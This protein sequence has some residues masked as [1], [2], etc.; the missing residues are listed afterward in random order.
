MNI[1][2]RE[3]LVATLTLNRC[4]PS[5]VARVLKF[6]PDGGQVGCRLRGMH[7]KERVWVFGHISPKQFIAAQ[8][9]DA[10]NAVDPRWWERRGLKRW[11]RREV[12][13][14]N[15]WKFPFGADRMG[16]AQFRETTR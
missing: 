15:L 2:G 12:Y 5:V 4:R 11:M 13:L 6:N 1:R 7:R 16:M 3:S 10:Y 14:D 9:I 8:G